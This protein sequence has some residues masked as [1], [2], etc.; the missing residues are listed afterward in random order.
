[1]RHN[2]LE[3]TVQELDSAIAA[4]IAT[5]E[6]LVRRTRELIGVDDALASALAC[7]RL[8]QLQ[9]ARV[10]CDARAHELA[11]DVTWRQFHASIR[12]HRAVWS[13]FKLG[14][15]SRAIDKTSRRRLDPDATRRELRG[16]VG[17]APPEADFKN[18]GLYARPGP[19]GRWSA[20]HERNFS[21][22]PEHILSLG[23]V[24]LCALNEP[25]QTPPPC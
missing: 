13:H 20:P 21:G 15:L 18:V 17:A 6:R 8:E 4:H 14:H 12:L 2:D 3:M 24:V 9:S 23:D 19:D 11:Q 1:M 7:V 16:S 25:R 10:L 22:Q 5:G